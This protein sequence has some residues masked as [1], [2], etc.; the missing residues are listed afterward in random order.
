MLLKAWVGRGTL[1]ARAPGGPIPRLSPSASRSVCW[2]HAAPSDVPWP[3]GMAD[4]PLLSAGEAWPEVLH[5]QACSAACCP[6]RLSVSR[7][8]LL[9]QCITNSARERKISSSLQLPDRVLNFLKDHFLMDGQVRSHLLLL[10]PRAR[11]QR[12]AVHRVRGLHHTYDVLFL[13]TG[14]CRQQGGFE[15]KAPQPPGCGP[16]CRLCS[17]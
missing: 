9:L 7:C 13:G 2:L 3:P 17:R 11:Y 15:V 4:A 1:P 10:Q 12:V 5:L 8:P 16:E 14:E 6:K